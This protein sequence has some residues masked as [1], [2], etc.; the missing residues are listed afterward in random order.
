MAR[1][2]RDLVEE[3]QL[4]EALQHWAIRHSKTHPEKEHLLLRASG[5]TCTPEAAQKL[6]NYGIVPLSDAALDQEVSIALLEAPRCAPN[7][8]EG[9]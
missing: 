7:D 4:L 8:A 9:T 1:R 3:F 2:N 5:R 6:A